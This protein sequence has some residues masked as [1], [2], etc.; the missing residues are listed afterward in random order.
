MACGRREQ[1]AERRLVSRPSDPLRRNCTGSTRG[2]DTRRIT[3]DPLLRTRCCWLRALRSRD[4]PVFAVARN[5]A[6]EHAQHRA[7]PDRFLSDQSR[8]ARG[9]APQASC[10]IR[11]RH[12]PEL[13]W[14]LLSAVTAEQSRLHAQRSAAAERRWLEHTDAR[15]PPRGWRTGSDSVPARP[16][17]HPYQ[18]EARIAGNDRLGIEPA[19]VESA[20]A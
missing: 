7:L 8:V 2:K 15:L 10:E 19:A 20:G 9:H 6:R 3:R 17:L 14:R 4:L 18:A 5:C 13:G 12:L 16:G 1:H 11:P